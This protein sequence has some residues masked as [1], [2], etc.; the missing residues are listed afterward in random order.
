METMLSNTD[1]ANKKEE[2][3]YKKQLTGLTNKKEKLA[4]RFA[5]GDIELEMYA[6]F[7]NQVEGKITDLEAKF[8]ISGIDLSNIKSECFI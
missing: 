4:E 5:F 1:K 8:D 6:K 2:A 3:I 7:L